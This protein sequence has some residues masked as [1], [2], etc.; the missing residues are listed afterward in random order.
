M[1][2]VSNKTVATIKDL[3]T[4][5]TLDELRA[6]GD[7]MAKTKFTPLKTGAE[8]VAAVLTGQELGLK[9]MF[10]ANNIYPIEGKATLG[11]HAINKLLL[12]AGIFAEVIREYEPCV[13]FVMKGSDDL[14]VLVDSNN[15]EVTRG[16]DKKAPDG[17]GP[18]IIREGFADE[19]PKSSEIKGKLIVN[20]KTVIKFTRK[21][22]QADGTFK[23][24]IAFGSYSYKE[25]SS[26]IINA[27]GKRLTEKSNWIN[28]PSQMCYARALAFGARR[29]GD[30]I[31]GGLPETGEYADVKNIEYTI[32]EEG[33]VSII[34]NEEE[35]PVNSSNVEEATEVNEVKEETSFNTDNI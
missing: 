28:F 19:E 27:S 35:K 17:S 25:A 14:A 26:V 9:P 24:V 11:I 30:D 18:V 32:K 20:Y 31:L 5:K 2:E 7:E 3:V 33:T 23:E 6:Y 10:S 15:K 4:F 22:K 16:A 21:L 8:I 34:K 29:I 1:E 13:N 12:E